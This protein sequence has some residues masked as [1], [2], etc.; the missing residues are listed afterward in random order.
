MKSV[1]MYLVRI[2]IDG[3]GRSSLVLVSQMAWKVLLGKH[4]Y[5]NT[6]AT[7]GQNATIRSNSDIQLAI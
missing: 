4:F 1:H 2:K 3:E 7:Y 5:R 6:V